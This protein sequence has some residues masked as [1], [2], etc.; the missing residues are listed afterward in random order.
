MTD[1]Y[2][3]GTSAACS[4]EQA[5]V[6][7]LGKLDG[8]MAYCPPA[9]L[10]I[11]AGRVLR[12]T[13][14]GAL[15]QE[16]HA[17]TD[18]RFQAWFAGLATLTDTLRRD[19][20]QPR[21]LCE[22]VL[23]ELTHGSWAPLADLAKLMEAALL[24]PRDLEAG[25]TRADAYD[26]IAEARALLSAL[27]SGDGSPLHAIDLLHDAVA[28]SPRFAPTE[29]S[30][31][32]F[33][34]GARRLTMERASRPS[35]R[36]AIEIVHGETLYTVG[37]LR[38]ALPLVGLIRIDTLQD[39]NDEGIGHARAARL[40]DLATTMAEHLDQAVKLARRLDQ[41]PAG[42]RSTSRA[43]LVFELLAGFGAMRSAQIEHMIGATRLGVSGMIRALDAMGLIERST[44]AGAHLFAAGSPPPIDALPAQ[45]E[46]LA[47]SGEA[48]DEYEA[49]LAE[50]DRLLGRAS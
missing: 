31:T 27:P 45:E 46:S 18:G 23:T 25:D 7:A 32:P 5:A 30:S 24:A 16:G 17:F 47:F 15:R 50:L 39:E 12:D 40:R 42:R 10:R 33:S 41:L 35:P 49:S 1:S 20:I 6:L 8:A 38:S 48:L 34:V 43:P 3:S 4:M 22:A 11:F 26:L 29:R 37:T 2:A 28:K 36:W 19:V 44:I 21:A 13:L 9:A 14:V